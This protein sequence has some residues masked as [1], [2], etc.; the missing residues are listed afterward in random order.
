ATY[1][2][3]L[4]SS[5][6]LAETDTKRILSNSAW[7]RLS[8]SART[9]SL[10]ASQ[11]NSRLMKRV[12]DRGSVARKSTICPLG[13]AL[14]CALLLTTVLL[15]RLSYGGR[16]RGFY[17]SETGDVMRCAEDELAPTVTLRGGL[18]PR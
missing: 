8:A 11:D 10:K 18:P 9:R 12:G 17:R 5:R 13:G 6:V 3:M 2:T 4:N 1:T 15:S 16:R 14:V 7:R